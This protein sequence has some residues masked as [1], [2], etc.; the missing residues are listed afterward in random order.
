MKKEQLTEAELQVMKCIWDAECELGLSEIVKRVNDKFKRNW[1]P[2][3]A[4]TFLA[5]LVQKGFLVLKRDSRYY[6]YQILIS[7]ECYL[8]K[9]IE[10][11]LEFWDNYSLAQIFALFIE[12]QN[13]SREQRIEIQ[14]ILEKESKFIKEG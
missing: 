4:S 12:N 11:F 3:T 10:D 2:Q 14:T 13:L 6:T 9:Q 1:K 7:E 8:K 5:R